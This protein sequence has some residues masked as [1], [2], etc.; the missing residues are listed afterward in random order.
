[1]SGGAASHAAMAIR[2][3]D[4]KLYINCV[5]IQDESFVLLKDYLFSFPNLLSSKIS[6]MI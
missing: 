3:E 1:M 5:N 2:L 4:D 6:S